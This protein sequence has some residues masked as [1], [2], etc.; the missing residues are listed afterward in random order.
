MIHTISHPQQ[1]EGYLVK[2][3]GL[4][5]TFNVGKEGLGTA[6]HKTAWSFSLGSYFVA[7]SKIIRCILLFNRCRIYALP[8]YNESRTRCWETTWAHQFEGMERTQVS[9]L[10]EVMSFWPI[11]NIPPL[12]RNIFEAEL[13]ALPH[14]PCHHYSLRQ[15]DRIA[16]ALHR[17]SCVAFAHPFH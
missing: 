3:L 12:W 11:K 10:C 5:L 4:R 2:L 1:G 17:L 7:S 9:I 14:S 8:I 6:L 13:L 16:F 15:E